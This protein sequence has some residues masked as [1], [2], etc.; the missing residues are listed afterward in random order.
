MSVAVIADAHIGGPGGPPEPLLEQLE[1][2][3]GGDCRHLLI[4]GDLFHVWVGDLRFETPEIRRVVEA[5]RALRRRGFRIDYVEGNRD[6]FL[7]D[8][9]YS[10]LFDRI[11]REVSFSADSRRYLAV[12]GD[13]LNARDRKYR[14]WRWLSKSRVSRFFMLHLPPGLAG[15]LMH[16]VERQLA[17]TN[18]KHKTLIPE[19][20]ILRYAGERLGRGFDVMLLG[21]FHEPRRWQ[22]E[23]GEVQLL[24]A[25]FRS[26]KVEWFGEQAG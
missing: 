8:S 18:F 19:E 16:G 7:A 22:L 13:G 5:L 3:R 9:A 6:F 17:K 15:H 21:H 25:W 24:D 4:L 11:A 1:E 26:R 23:H 14:F 20:V 10:D 2:L 12:H